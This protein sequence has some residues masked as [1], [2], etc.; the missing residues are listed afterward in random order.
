[1]HGGGL[2][3]QLFA[4]LAIAVIAAAAMAAVVA[5]HVFDREL[6]RAL[7]ARLQ[8][9]VAETGRVMD[10]GIAAGLELDRPQLQERAIR[11][12]R[13]NLAADEVIA[14]VD[15]A[16]RI[17]ASSN[18]AEIGELVP[19]QTL[20]TP[21]LGA[22]GD[23]GERTVAVRPIQSLFGA[24]AGFVTAK[25]GPAALDQPR[26][27]F[28]AKVSLTTAAI[29][30]AGLLVA[31][32]AA[33]WLPWRARGVARGLEKHMAALYA[34]IGTSEPS[35]ASPGGLPPEMGEALDRFT[36]AVEAREHELQAHA[37]AVD[38]LDEAA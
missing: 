1:M 36:R 37:D 33:A 6:D 21:A 12:L 35:P 8:M 25:L 29:T 5:Y 9:L 17:V 20:A 26:R 19:T 18:P 7:E 24:P 38:L 16:G 10:A 31:A 28:I 34:G 4:A 32:L 11:N 22:A 23:G 13:A 2:R 27:A 14:V 3:L 15:S 30:L